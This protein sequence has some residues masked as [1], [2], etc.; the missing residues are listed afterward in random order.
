M[1]QIREK[2]KNTKGAVSLVVRVTCSSDS[3]NKQQNNSVSNQENKV[4]HASDELTEFREKYK[5]EVA[6]KKLAIKLQ[7]YEEKLQ[8]MGDA[9]LA[10]ELLSK[11]NVVIDIQNEKWFPKNTTDNEFF[12]KKKKEK[13]DDVSINNKIKDKT[14][15]KEK[16]TLNQANTKGMHHSELNLFLTQK[17]LRDSKQQ[18]K[19]F[20]DKF[21]GKLNKFHAGLTKSQRSK[22]K[23]FI[24]HA[25]PNKWLDTSEAWLSQFKLQLHKDLGEAGLN[26]LL[27]ER[28]NPKGDILVF[29]RLINHKDMSVVLLCTKTLKLKIESE[30]HNYLVKEEYKIIANKFRNHLIELQG[31]AK[32]EN[33]INKESVLSRLTIQIQILKDQIDLISTRIAIVECKEKK[34]AKQLQGQLSKL[35]KTRDQL[36]S[37]ITLNKDKLYKNKLIDD[38]SKQLE[39]Q[40]TLEDV[41]VKYKLTNP[42]IRLLISGR[43]T[44]ADPM[45]GLGF[46]TIMAVDHDAFRQDHKEFTASS[47][48]VNYYYCFKSLINAI[49]QDH[50][51]KQ[52]KDK[53]TNIFANTDKQIAYGYKE[54]DDRLVIHNKKL[55][56]HYV[57]NQVNSRFTFYTLIRK[58]EIQRSLKG[59]YTTQNE[60][61]D[62]LNE[63]KQTLDNIYINLDIVNQSNYEGKQKVFA[64]RIQDNN[65]AKEIKIKEKNQEGD[66]IYNARKQVMHLYTNACGFKQT[67]QSQQMFEKIEIAIRENKKTIKKTY[68]AAKKI[69]IT[70]EPGIGKSTLSQY[71]ANKWG[72]GEQTDKN[73]LWQNKF[74]YVFWLPLKNLV[75]Y[76]DEKDEKLPLNLASILKQ[77]CFL[78]KSEISLE[79]IEAVLKRCGNKTLMILDGYDEITDIC[80]QKTHPIRQILDKLFGEGKYFGMYENL[81]VLMTT[82]PYSTSNYKF[83]RVLQNVGFN[84]DNIKQYVGKYFGKDKK[85]SDALL[86]YIEA[87]SEL[88]GISYVPLNLRL[89]CNICENTDEDLSKMSLAE[90]YQVLIN[91]F[92]KQYLIKQADDKNKSHIKNYTANKVE[93]FTRLETAFLERLSF[94]GMQ[95]SKVVFGGKFQEEILSKVEKLFENRN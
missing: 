72:K 27:D 28:D 63:D 65:V 10:K 69:L 50:I 79:E 85:K 33:V 74:D 95:Q 73:S 14:E 70:G 40:L 24:S 18:D 9:N 57:Y 39:D 48:A 92:L 87:S 22:V 42:I 86:H 89:L 46:G 80:N 59:Y 84:Q 12:K 26:V 20:F 56:K 5:S 45:H 43:I 23:G 88:K 53:L 77:E 21:L 1:D 90:L 36:I 82:R 3:N 19:D 49:Y 64:N 13:T 25:F 67:I 78:D 15:K 81:H 93:K 11:Q 6:D 75:T 17:L 76:L 68:P 66:A 55:G 8:I 44:E 62:L 41:R 52:D 94:E 71:L 38:K 31:F 29:E 35:L 34:T 60:L 30:T 47:Y 37:K 51:T 32:K 61:P 83:D 54:V 2:I 7:L 4:D 91:N 16:K 58:A